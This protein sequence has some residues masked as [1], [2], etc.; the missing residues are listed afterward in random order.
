MT[1]STENGAGTPYDSSLRTRDFP[2]SSRCTVPRTRKKEKKGQRVSVCLSQPSA[3]R[4][5]LTCSGCLS[6]KPILVVVPNL[7]GSTPT[8]KCIRGSVSVEHVFLEHL[9]DKVVRFED[10]GNSDD[11]EGRRSDWCPP[12]NALIR[13]LNRIRIRQ[14]VW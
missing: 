3:K 5:V 13:N 8:P 1:D 7:L 12:R 11:I 9:K 2:R 14:T 4:S 6:S 10:T